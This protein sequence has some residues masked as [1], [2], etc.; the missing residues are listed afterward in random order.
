MIFVQSFNH[1]PNARESAGIRVEWGGES[2]AVT[3]AHYLRD[4]QAA[5]VVIAVK[6]LLTDAM[7]EADPAKEW[8][9][10]THVSALGDAIAAVCTNA[11]ENGARVDLT[12]AP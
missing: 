1:V 6:A 7:I 2:S 8:P 4:S 11:V 10:Y 12:A 9:G 5:A 3:I